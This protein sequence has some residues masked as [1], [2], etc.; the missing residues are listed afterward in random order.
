MGRKVD[1]MIKRHESSLLCEDIKLIKISEGT[2][3]VFLGRIYQMG[4]ITIHQV[5]QRFWTCFVPTF[6][7]FSQAEMY[8]INK[9]MNDLLAKL[10]GRVSEASET[11]CTKPRLEE[12]IV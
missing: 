4:M 3:G 12:V 1:Q 11:K 5:G 2:Y 10:T 6:R 9:L 8:T 7:S